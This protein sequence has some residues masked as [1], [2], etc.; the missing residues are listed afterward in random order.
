MSRRQMWLIGMPAEPVRTRVPWSSHT[1]WHAACRCHGQARRGRVGCDD[2]L[3]SMT[4]DDT[5]RAGASAGPLDGDKPVTT[6]V[7]VGVIANPASGRDIRRLT[8]HAS[9]FPTAEKANMVV[10]L[11]AGLGAMVAEPELSLVDDM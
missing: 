3:P 8:T 2:P 4:A 1:R 5:C 7:T 6:P 11:L 10:R 9:V